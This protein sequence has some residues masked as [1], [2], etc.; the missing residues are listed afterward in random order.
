MTHELA[1]DGRA[2]AFYR[3]CYRTEPLGGAEPLA[4]ALGERVGRSGV[5]L[6]VGLGRPCVEDELQLSH[7]L[8]VGRGCVFGANVWVGKRPLV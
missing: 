1:G 4:D 5:P 2:E 8:L 7:A 3:R 6:R